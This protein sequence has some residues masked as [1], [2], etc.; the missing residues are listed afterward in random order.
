MH[1]ILQDFLDRFLRATEFANTG[2][3]GEALCLMEKHHLAEVE[4]RQSQTARRR[5]RKL[6]QRPRQFHSTTIEPAQ[7]HPRWR[8]KVLVAACMAPQ[9]G[10]LKETC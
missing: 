2:N 1:A 8:G 5:V 6:M 10:R 7:R 9:G 3:L 4:Q